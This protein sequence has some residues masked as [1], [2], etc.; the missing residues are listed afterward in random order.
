MAVT[1]TLTSL[2]NRFSLIQ[3]IEQTLSSENKKMFCVIFL[4][5]DYFKGINDNFGHEIGDEILKQFS[6]KISDSIFP[7][8]ILSRFGGD[9]FVVLLKNVNTLE[10][11]KSTISEISK[12]LDTS[13]TID[14]NEIYVS[15]SI[16]VSIYSPDSGIVNYKKLLKQADSA[17]YTAKES[18]RNCFQFF[19]K[20]SHDKIQREYS[21]S[22]ALNSIIKNENKDNKLT[23]KYQPILN[24][25]DNNF[26]E[27]EA[28]L[29]WT[30]DKDEKI[31]TYEFIS[32]ANKKSDLIEKINSIVIKEICKQQS[33]WQKKQCH[34]IRI[35]VNL[36]GNKTYFSH[37]LE[38]FEESI[39]KYK[40]SPSQF[41]IDL[42][43]KTII[44]ATK[45]TIIILTKL[46]KQAMK[47]SIDDFGTGYSSLS[48][49]KKLPIS[50]IRIDK[51]FISGLAN[52]SDDQE[53]VKTIITVGHTLNL[54][55]VAEGVETSEQL[56]F[57][58]D[59]NCDYAQGYYFHNPLNHAKLTDLH[60]VS[61]VQQSKQNCLNRSTMLAIN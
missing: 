54:D 29:R 52:I 16:G 53:L 51:S 20:E 61:R 56:D 59:H 19:S 14:N 22:Q 58:L 40:L 9:E 33:E 34:N 25:S 49:L 27:C 57:L 10:Q 46:R 60:H 24:I 1:D 12:S 3:H 4:D 28:L 17:M 39:N 45:E 23:L 36:S 26:N 11:A 31:P 48:Y 41:G 43:E 6:N 2:P 13:F 32:I 7:G 15:S 42:N 55:I 21:I 18:G 35:N 44:E 38:E 47:I 37:L 5:I 50:T 30:T 8:D